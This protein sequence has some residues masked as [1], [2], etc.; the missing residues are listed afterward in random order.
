MN[1]T[2]IRPYLVVR[3]IGAVPILI[4][5]VKG[6]T[7][8]YNDDIAWMLLLTALGL[9]VWFVSDRMRKKNTTWD[10]LR[11]VPRPIYRWIRKP[12]RRVCLGGVRPI[13]A[14]SCIAV[15]G[16]RPQR[17]DPGTSPSHTA[18]W[19][20]AL[21]PTLRPVPDREHR[22]ADQCAVRLG[23]SARLVHCGHLPSRQCLK[24]KRAPRLRLRALAERRPG[25]RRNDR[26]PPPRHRRRRS[27]ARTE[28]LPRG[29]ARRRRDHQDVTDKKETSSPA[30]TVVPESIPVSTCPSAILA[31]QMPDISANGPALC[32]AP[33]NTRKPT[34]PFR[35]PCYV[36]S[37]LF[38][39]AAESTT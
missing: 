9:T 1:A 38:T 30:P 3:A 35:T 24:C 23:R 5:G 28:R 19:S 39:R 2:G 26:A 8:F 11:A 22:P 33:E 20:W 31:D 10:S 29:H 17:S 34:S 18:A 15:L 4:V 21:G 12:C 37:I 7:G 25:R 27:I 16:A 32:T 14:R 36:L 6:I 13:R